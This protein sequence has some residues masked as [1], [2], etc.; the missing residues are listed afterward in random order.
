MGGPGQTVGGPGQTVGGP[1]QTVGGPGQTVGGPFPK[2]L[3]I[4]KSNETI[5]SFYT[6]RIDP[7]ID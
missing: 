7:K 6:C 5:F 3:F 1:G 4:R 2:N